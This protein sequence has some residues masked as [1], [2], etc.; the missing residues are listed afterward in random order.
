[1]TASFPYVV[2][3]D[4]GGCKSVIPVAGFISVADAKR[5]ATAEHANWHLSSYVKVVDEYDDE[6]VFE[7]GDRH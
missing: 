3:S 7:L 2:Y 6:V 4:N 5:Y 1:M